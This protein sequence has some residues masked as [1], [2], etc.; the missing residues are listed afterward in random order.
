MRWILSQHFVP[1]AKSIKRKQQF[2]ET[3]DDD[4]IVAAESREDSIKR[5]YFLPMV[6]QA[7]AS[8]TKRFEQYQGQYENTFFYFKEIMLLR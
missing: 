3:P 4:K 7:I 6:D 8:L 1:S 5:Y 2:D